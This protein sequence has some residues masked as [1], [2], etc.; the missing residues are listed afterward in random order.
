VPLSDVGRSVESIEYW[1]RALEISGEFPMARGNRGYGLYRYARFLHDEGHQALFLKEA[2]RDFSI[3]LQFELYRDAEISFK[4]IKTRIELTL[5]PGFLEKEIDLNQYPLGD[6][7]EEVSYR[8]WCINQKLFINPLN[9]LGAYSIAAT[10]VLHLPSIVVMLGEGAYYAGLFNQLKQEFVSARFLLYEGLSISAPH[11]SDRDVI[12]RNTLD[13]PAYSLAIEKVKL[14]FRSAYSLFDKVAFFL[15]HY[16]D[17]AVPHRNISFKTIWYER[18]SK[19]MGISQKIIALNNNALTGLFWLS[20]DLSEAREDFV[21]A[22]EPD[23]QE[24]EQLRQ[25][26]EHRYLKIHESFFDLD[27][28]DHP[29]G[30]V[31]TDTLAK[32]VSRDVF[33][34]KSLRM[35]RL[36]RAA[37]IYLCLIVQAEEE[38]RSQ[39][40]SPESSVMPIILDTWEDNWKC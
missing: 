37:L 24:I 39:E 25:H 36:S 30:L 40:R 17:L 32:S 18:G 13:Y 19:K 14:A 28:K 3:V 11:Y 1:S 8:K 27:H 31:L 29:Q 26:A 12:L 35:L 20:K 21:D 34:A 5:D 38:R 6:S 10:D 9:D 22:M 2:Y 16:L 7:F 23:A 33:C 15:N 4:E